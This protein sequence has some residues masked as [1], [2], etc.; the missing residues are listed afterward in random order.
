[1]RCPTCRSEDV[2]V[3]PYDFGRCSQTGYHDAG[4]RFRCHACGAMGDSD[5]LFEDEEDGEQ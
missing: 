4:E 1:M 2:A 3:Q 5:E